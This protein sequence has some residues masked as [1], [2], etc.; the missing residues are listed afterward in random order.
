MNPF[1]EYLSGQLESLLA[2]HRVVVFYDPRSEFVPFFD[3]EL[4]AVGAGPDDLASVSI[5]SRPTLL[6]RYSGSYFGLRAKVEAIVAADEPDC[7]VVYLPGVE[8]NRNASVLMELERGG[9]CYEPQLRRLARTVLR[10][11]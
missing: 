9:A 1:H 7:L 2:K 6:A 3:R 11:F 10:Q 8:R 5:S 4:Q